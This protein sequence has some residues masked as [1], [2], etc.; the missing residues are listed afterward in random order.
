MH[1]LG[2]E[3]SLSI[4][5]FQMYGKLILL[6]PGLANKRKTLV[7]PRMVGNTG[8]S[9]ELHCCFPGNAGKLITTTHF[10]KTFNHICWYVNSWTPCK[11]WY[12]IIVFSLLP[13][14][15]AWARAQKA[16]YCWHSCSF[17]NLDS[18]AVNRGML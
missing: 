14:Y 9:W 11:L 10:I 8:I 18:E 6:F 4:A 12:F 15:L 5:L 7:F 1:R 17:N 2:R 3:K 16:A 13:T